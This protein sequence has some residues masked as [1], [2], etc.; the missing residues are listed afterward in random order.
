MIFFL[1]DN[2]MKPMLIFSTVI[3]IASTAPIPHSTVESHDILYHLVCNF[4]S[5]KHVF[6]YPIDDGKVAE[7]LV[8]NPFKIHPE[9]LTETAV[10]YM[11]PMCA[12]S[13]A[14]KREV[15]HEWFISNENFINY[16]KVKTKLFLTIRCLL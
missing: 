5:I 11:G 13:G 8:F 1:K 7:D 10:E 14:T 2:Q 16:S 12:K 4:S 15:N 6:Y 9:K 3:F